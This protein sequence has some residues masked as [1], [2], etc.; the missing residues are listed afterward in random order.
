MRSWSAWCRAAR[1]S[2]S[3]SGGEEV[4]SAYGR[5]FRPL[6]ASLGVT[7]KAG[8]VT[9]VPTGKSSSGLLVI[10][11]LGRAATDGLIS[12]TG[13]RRAAGAAAR[14]VTNAASDAIA[15]P[16]DS[17]EQVRAV[18]EGLLGGYRFT[19]YKKKRMATRGGASR[20]GRRAQP[21]GAEEGV[22]EGLRGCAGR[23]RDRGQHPR[24]GEHAPRRL[25]APSLR[26]RP[27]RPPPRTCRRG[28]GRR[29]R[30]RSATRRRWPTSAAAASSAWGLG[31]AAPPRLVELTWSPRNPVAH[32]AL[33]GKG[34]TFDSGGLD[35]QARFR[36]ERHEVATWPG[37]PPWCRRRSR[38]PGSACRSR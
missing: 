22:H 16:A 33:V 25:H 34:I 4:G 11:G 36:D 3:L 5:T 21:V 1:D 35:H 15:L 7:G 19:T 18:T 30:S 10:V 8:E 32:L 12:T 29:S 9:K 2:R 14:A 37:L 17:V 6:L 28:A 20:R 24:L 26:R 27:S 23:R 13:V 31:S 38:S